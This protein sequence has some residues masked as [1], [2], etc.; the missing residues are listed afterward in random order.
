MS[1]DASK[2]RFLAKL[3]LANSNAGVFDGKAWGGAGKVF[4]SMNPTTNRAILQIS[5]PDMS[6]YERC[7][8][9]MTA[10]QD[11]WSMMPIPARGE[12][13][14]ALGQ[15]F[16][17][18]KT[19]LGSVISLEMGK[20]QKEGEGEVQ[21]VIDMCDFAC[22]LSRQLN[23]KVIPSERKEHALLEQ[24]N[25]LGNVGVIT[26][27]NFP[28]AVL[29]WNLCLAMICGNCTMWKGGES[30]GLTTIAV[31]KLVAKVFADH[32]VPQG[33]FTA[34]MG[35]GATIGEKMIN[36]PRINLISFTGS[37]VVGRHVAKTVAG[38]F[39]KCLLEL[40]GNNCSIIMEDA[41]IEMAVK[42]C[43]FGAVG[44]AGQRCTTLRR[45]AIHESKYREVVDMLCSAYPNL[46]MGDPLVDGTLMG[47]LHNQKAVQAYLQ[48]IETAK[49]QGGKV[50][51]GGKTVDLHGGNFV[52]PTIVEIDPYAPIGK[53]Y[54]FSKQISPAGNIRSNFVRFPSER[55]H[56]GCENQQHGATRSELFN[57]HQEF[58]VCLCLD[59]AK[60]Q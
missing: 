4:T 41:D 31:S 8:A 23:G 33:V 42:G 45:L 9:N 34:F 16:R 36:D 56:R 55:F 25:P 30:A 26:A 21:E 51:Y 24:W 19:E 49:A 40:G 29:G 22:G 54:Y 58:R 39:G 37:T 7:V 27:F 11:E 60:R 5:S 53:K 43:I 48:T 28:F 12:I 6:D 52:L 13:V 1:L 3:G 44:T 46:P 38:R 35:D 17:N 10:A 14:R 15:E 32:K 18:Y 59:W 57:L 20:I 50:L 2:F 47:P